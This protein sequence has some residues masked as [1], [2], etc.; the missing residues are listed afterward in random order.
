MHIHIYI[1]HILYKTF[2]EQFSNA[3]YEDLFLPQIFN[4]VVYFGFQLFW[5]TKKKRNRIRN[6]F[7]FD[8]VSVTSLSCTYTQTLYIV[9]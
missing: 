9:T 2:K 3:R 7:Q 5:Q 1:N 4:A 8:N 6:V